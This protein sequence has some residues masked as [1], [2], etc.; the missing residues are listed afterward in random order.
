M[1]DMFT[2][3]YEDIRNEMLQN[4]HEKYGIEF[5]ADSLERGSQDY[6]IAFPAGG[7]MQEDFVRIQRHGTGGSVRFND[8]FFGV[9]IRDDLESGVAAALAGIGLPFKVFFSTDSFAFNN[10]FNGTKNLADF[11]AWIEDGNSSRLPITIIL[12]VETND[13][14]ETVANAAFKKIQKTGYMLHVTLNFTPNE[15]FEQ[16]TRENRVNML[17]QHGSEMTSFTTSIN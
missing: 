14:A 5:T 16:I 15:I 3:S 7:N 11:N 17:M 4:L 10:K 1:L 2:E 6:L 13:G 9:I 12:G 8:T